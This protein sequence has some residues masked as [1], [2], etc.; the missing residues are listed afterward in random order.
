[1]RSFRSRAGEDSEE[2]STREEQPHVRAAS[3]RK[4]S[5]CNYIELQ[6]YSVAEECTYEEEMRLFFQSII[7]VFCSC[8]VELFSERVERVG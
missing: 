4:P 5:V 8:V 7:S 1:M 3:L 6:D 2:L